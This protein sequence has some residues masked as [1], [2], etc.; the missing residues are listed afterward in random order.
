MGAK[1]NFTSI[2]KHQIGDLSLTFENVFEPYK[3]IKAEKI[4]QELC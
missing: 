1:Y 4:T 2:K 3:I